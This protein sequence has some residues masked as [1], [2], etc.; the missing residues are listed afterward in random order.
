MN[1]LVKGQTADPVVIVTYR[2]Y[3]QAHATCVIVCDTE[4]S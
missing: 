4:A 1:K 2:V 3:L